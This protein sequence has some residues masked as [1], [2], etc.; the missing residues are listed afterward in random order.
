M[1][2]LTKLPRFMEFLHQHYMKYYS[3]YNGRLV[4]LFPS[5][6]ATEDS[7]SISEDKNSTSEEDDKIYEL[8]K[9]FK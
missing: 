9:E 2:V 4:E 7:L 6:E 8:W 3:L 1:I 5:S